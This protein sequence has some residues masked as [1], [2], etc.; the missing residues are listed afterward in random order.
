MVP[1]VMHK[2]LFICD[3]NIAVYMFLFAV[4]Y[5]LPVFVLVHTAHWISILSC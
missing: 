2:Q 4:A 3:C 5:D 1:D